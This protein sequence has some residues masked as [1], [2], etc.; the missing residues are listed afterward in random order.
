MTMFWLGAGSMAVVAVLLLW[1]RSLEGPTVE[2]DLLADEAA[3]KE[4]LSNLETELTAKYDAVTAQ[5][6]LEANAAAKLC[7]T[8]TAAG[9][10]KVLAAIQTELGKLS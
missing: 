5:I 7:L 10:E 4:Y 3:L 6:V 2:A 1:V 8:S 9:L